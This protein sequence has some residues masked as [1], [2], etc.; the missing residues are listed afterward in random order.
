MDTTHSIFTKTGELNA[1]T[2]IDVIIYNQPQEVWEVNMDPVNNFMLESGNF[3]SF[4]I[5]HNL[6][7][8]FVAGT[9]VTMGDGTQ[10]NIEDINE[11]EEV[12]SFNEE[13]LKSEVKKVIGLK[14]PI[15]NDMIKVNFSNLD[16]VTCTFDHPFYADGMNLVSYK[17]NLT[18]SRYDLGREVNQMKVGQLIKMKVGHTSITSIEEL[19]MVDTQTY[20]ITVEDNHNFF[21]NNILVHNK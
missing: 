20:I 6:G 21:V 11:G 17:P 2:S 1:I 16:S 5:T 7:S 13:T 14:R 18:N 4:F 10:K 3:M 12:L 9:Q 19:P 15:H 8:C